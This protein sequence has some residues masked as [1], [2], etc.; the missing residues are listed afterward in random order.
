MAAQ[1]PSGRAPDV[2]HVTMETDVKTTGGHA[3]EPVVIELHRSWAPHGVDR[4]WQLCTLTAPASNPG[5]MRLARNDTFFTNGA[6]YRVVPHFVVQF[7]INGIPAL[8]RPWTPAIPDDPVTQSNVRGTFTYAAAGANTRTT[9]VFINL[10][11]NKRL[12][13]M[14]FAP[15]G[16]VVNGMATVDAIYNPTPGVSGGIDQGKYTSLGNHWLLSKYPRTNTVLR[17]SVSVVGGSGTTSTT[18]PII[19]VEHPKPV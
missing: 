9:Q 19:T 3:A 13:T 17:S 6:F 18:P 14:G 11:D 16:R 15:I 5:A 12:D 10:V 4:F 7:G 2:F 1:A 8:N